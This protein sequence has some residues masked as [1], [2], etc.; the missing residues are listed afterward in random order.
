MSTSTKDKKP[1]CPLCHAEI[2]KNEFTEIVPYSVT[3]RYENGKLVHHTVDHPCVNHDADHLDVRFY[4]D[5]C[6]TEFGNF[7]DLNTLQEIDL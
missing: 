1:A 3:L 2:N 7:I 6:C 5:T 4:C